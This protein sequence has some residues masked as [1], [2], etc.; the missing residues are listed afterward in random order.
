[1][2]SDKFNLL[3][4]AMETSPNECNMLSL[5]Y[6]WDIQDKGNKQMEFRRAIQ[7]RDVNLN[8]VVSWLYVKVCGW[9]VIQGI[10]VQK[11]EIRV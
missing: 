5:N 2:S 10:Y 4:Q 1:M 3:I 8:S 11:D 7:N 6:P 9:F